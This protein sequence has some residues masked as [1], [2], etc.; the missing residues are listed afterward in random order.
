MRDFLAREAATYRSI[1]ENLPED[2]ENEGQHQKKRIFCYFEVLFNK[3]DGWTEHEAHAEVESVN[4]WEKKGI[5]DYDPDWRDRNL[6]T[7]AFSQELM[8]KR[9]TPEKRQA[10]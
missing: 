10:M 6:R 4:R 3:R 1:C 5:K 7:A 9:L 8:S 2:D